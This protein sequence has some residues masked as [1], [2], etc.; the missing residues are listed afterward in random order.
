MFDVDGMSGT[1]LSGRASPSSSAAVDDRA[2]VSVADLLLVFRE[3]H[4]AELVEDLVIGDRL[5]RRA[6]V[7]RDGV[8]IRAAALAAEE[9]GLRT[10]LARLVDRSL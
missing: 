8:P 9:E 10:R 2:P 6:P 5:R 4:D 3:P 1:S 7:R